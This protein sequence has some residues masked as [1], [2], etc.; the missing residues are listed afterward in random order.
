SDIT[1]KRLHDYFRSRPEFKNAFGIVNEP[2]ARRVRLRLA[3]QKATGGANHPVKRTELASH[4]RISASGIA[5]FLRENPDLA[6]E[7]N[8]V[9]DTK[10]SNPK[11]EVE[12]LDAVSKM[13]DGMPRTIRT[14]ARVLGV[15]EDSLQNFFSL[16]AARKELRRTLGIL[17]EV[18]YRRKQK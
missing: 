6:H 12:V 1:E 2:E 11:K 16:N 14:L 7:L 5:K 10:G 8:I 17:N 3:V 18:E 9:R 4:L 15:T 13:P